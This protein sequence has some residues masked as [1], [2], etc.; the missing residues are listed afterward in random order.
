MLLVFAIALTPWALVHNH[1]KAPRPPKETNCHHI[2]HVESHSENCLICAFGFEKN[3]VQTHNLYNIFLSAKIF[4]P[5][6]NVISSSFVEI[7]QT[8]LRGPPLV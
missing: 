7:K 8:C 2:S 1:N 6:V 5:V 3:F 4:N